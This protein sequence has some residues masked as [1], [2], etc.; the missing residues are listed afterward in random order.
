ME[1]DQINPMNNDDFNDLDQ[2]KLQEKRGFFRGH[3]VYQYMSG[4]GVIT[5]RY[6]SNSH[7]L[8]YQSPH[9]SHLSITSNSDVKSRKSLTIDNN[10]DECTMKQNIN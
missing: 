6:V 4:V 8:I 2:H 10:E 5:E 3:I 1:Q 7:L 9:S